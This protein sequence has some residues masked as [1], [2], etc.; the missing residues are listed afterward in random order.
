MIEKQIVNMSLYR[1]FISIIKTYPESFVKQFN[2]NKP[3]DRE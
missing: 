2:S 1:F 3:E